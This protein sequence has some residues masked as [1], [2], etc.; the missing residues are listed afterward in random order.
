MIVELKAIETLTAIHEVQL[1]NYLA[2]TGIETGLL[3]NFGSESL[4][5]KRKFRHFKPKQSPS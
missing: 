3:L 4:Q 1:V 2:A 5:P